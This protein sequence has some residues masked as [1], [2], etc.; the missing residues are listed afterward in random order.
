VWKIAGAA[1]Q[2]LHSAI[3]PTAFF[4]A[5]SHLFNR[6]MLLMLQVDREVKPDGVAFVLLVFS[7]GDSRP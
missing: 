1:A 7:R 2:T 5:S 4:S 3:D 6:P